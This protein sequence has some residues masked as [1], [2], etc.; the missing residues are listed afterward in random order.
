MNRVFMPLPVI[1]GGGIMFLGLTSGCS[2][3]R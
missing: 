1:S 3:V 2:S